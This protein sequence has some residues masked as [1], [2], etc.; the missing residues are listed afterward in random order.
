[1][2]HRSNIFIFLLKA[3]GLPLIPSIC[4][5]FKISS[6]TMASA[7]R[8]VMVGLP[9]LAVSVP[10]FADL[11]RANFRPNQR[12]AVPNL[13]CTLIVP[14]EPLTSAGLATPYELVATD[15][16]AGPCHEADGNQRAF[17]QAA[18]ID[19]DTGQISVYDPLVIDKGTTPA[20]PPVAPVL[21]TH[22]L[23][24][25]WFG[26]NGNN[27][28]LA[29]VGNPNDLQLNTCEQNFGQFAQCNA[30]EF[31][32]Q[33]KKLIRTGR[34]SVPR[35]GRDKTPNHEV[36]PSIR[37]FFVVDQDQSDNVTTSY[38]LTTDGRVAQNTATNRASLSDASVIGNPSDNRLL[39][40]FIDPALGCTAWTVP[41]LADP[42]ASVPA[43]PLNELQADKFQ[44]PPI[45]L[46]PLGNPFVLNPPITGVPDL[47]RVNLYRRGVGQPRAQNPDDA[48]T[49]KYC[50][51]LR[52]VQPAKLFRNKSELT[53]FQSPNSDVANSL[54]TFLSERYVNTYDILK[55]QELLNKP[56][57]VELT[58]DDAGIVV[59]A[60]PPK[61]K[62]DERPEQIPLDANDIVDLNSLE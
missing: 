58:T 30:V 29:A 35:L 45:A 31:F 37:S 44:G 5:R 27:L 36:S 53:A 7:A 49:T 13:N 61:T 9:L 14:R 4:R 25:L 12:V 10:A 54:F 20:I 28:K 52:A 1:M 6:M 60:T 56:V 55:C 62:Q 46:I 26:Y 33:A 18:I 48:S 39:D 38:L 22:H 41:N 15:P 59:D 42:G 19:L 16:A 43:L 11:N 2:K 3:L 47:Q 57:N 17:V 21:P 50:R 24:A 32:R 40:A 51:K 23:V 8:L 34:L